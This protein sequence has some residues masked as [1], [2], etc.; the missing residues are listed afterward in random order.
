MGR[1]TR[2]MTKFEE[3]LFNKVPCKFGTINKIKINSAKQAINA[4]IIIRN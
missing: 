4:N 2:K 1:R 3:E